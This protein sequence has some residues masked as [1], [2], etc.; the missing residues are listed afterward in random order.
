MSEELAFA[1]LSAL[2]AP[3][4]VCP[5]GLV[6][7]GRYGLFNGNA[8]IDWRCGTARIIRRP[9]ILPLTSSEHAWG[10]GT[11]LEQVLAHLLAEGLEVGGQ[12]C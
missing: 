7:N 1:M 10:A 2:F 6:R 5:V 8:L 12:A 11:R 4:A 3:A 9:S